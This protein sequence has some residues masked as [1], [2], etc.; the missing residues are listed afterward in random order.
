MWFH[1][2]V[3]PVQGFPASKGDVEPHLLPQPAAPGWF[4][5]GSAG[6]GTVHTITRAGTKQGGE[7]RRG[8]RRKET[9]TAVQGTAL[10]Q[11]QLIVSLCPGGH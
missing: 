1:I 5:V 10:D 9:T 4:S 8:G 2:L 3:T 7:H 6:P 11:L